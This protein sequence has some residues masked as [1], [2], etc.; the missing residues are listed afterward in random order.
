MFKKNKKVLDIAGYGAAVLTQIAEPIKE[1]N[2]EI[3]TLSGKMIETMFAFDGIGLA[4]PQVSK[5]L[6]MFVLGI[7]VDDDKFYDN[8][9]PDE[10]SLLKQMPVTF[11]N[12]SIISS[13]EECKTKE[14]GC[15]SIYEVYGN[16]TRPEKIVFTAQLLS[17]ENIT[18]E[19]TGLLSRALQHECDHLNGILYVDKMNEEDA[20]QIAKKLKKL[21]RNNKKSKFLRFF[22]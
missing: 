4:A 19:A 2:E 13:S 15:L 14:E 12:P 7:M 5:S 18:L 1:I 6:Q 8:L 11:I 17:G 16:V 10:V 9:K 21:K 20:A 22:K 3:I